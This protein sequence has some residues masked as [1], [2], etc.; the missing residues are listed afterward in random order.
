[1]GSFTQKSIQRNSLGSK[2]FIMG[3]LKDIKK[4]LLAK[5]KEL[6]A[7]EKAKMDEESKSA[8]GDRIKPLPSTDGLDDE[9][10][11]QLARE[12]HA[13]IDKADEQRYD[14]IYKVE[15]S[16]KETE[17]LANKHKELKSKI[18]KPTLKRLKMTPDE[19]FSTLLAAK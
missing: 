1:M 9:Q 7:A 13:A 17:E 15:K 5:G 19:M 4:K 6:I 16:K 10:L 3:D 14:A 2:L 12:L 8:I 11:K 18:K